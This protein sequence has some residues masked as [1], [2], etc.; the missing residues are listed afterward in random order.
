MTRPTKRSLRT[1]LLLIAAVATTLGALG[2]AVGVYGMGR[3]RAELDQVI[4]VDLGALELTR[5][6]QL[7]LLQAE[8]SRENMMLASWDDQRR[9]AKKVLDR[10][11]R[12]FQETLAKVRA[13]SSRDQSGV[14]E[15]VSAVADAWTP[16][17][18]AFVTALENEPVGELSQSAV[19]RDLAVR[20]R[21]EKLVS[22]LQQLADER[23]DRVA[24][25]QQRSAVMGKRM[26]LLIVAATLAST[27]ASA[28]VC[29]RLS[30][31]VMRQLGAEPHELAAATARVAEGD[32][33]SL[34]QAAP[35][36]G[37][38]LA[39]MQQMQE[40]LR[41]AMRAVADG[42]GI[43]TQSSTNISAG[44]FDL[45]RRTEKQADHVQRATSLV[46]GLARS[47]SVH[48]GHAREARES[49]ERATVVAGNAGQAMDGVQ[50][51]MT[52]IRETSKQVSEITS[53]IDSIAFQTNI[54]ALNAAVESA[55]AG[56]AGKGFS[57]VADE[58]RQLALR[59]SEASRDIRALTTTSSAQVAEGYSQVADAGRTIGQAIQEIVRIDTLVGEMETS[60][61]SLAASVQQANES[62]SV[63]EQ[64]TRQSSALVERT[65]AA[66]ESLRHEADRL[67]AAVG[68][69][70][71]EEE[72]EGTGGLEEKQAPHAPPP[73][74]RGG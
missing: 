18:A 39:S 43:V 35:L 74:R 6:A 16:E 34:A 55:R 72:P 58:V 15:A 60:N 40:R 47:M 25:S 48:S 24:K 69:F 41:V 32:L 44:N 17:I 68:L 63:I 38:V 4:D 49:V 21:T 5:Q 10:N 61:S 46:N 13:A 31:R 66:A 42:A 14:I 56:A 37:S 30:R 1:Q 51:A 64:A 65:A 29:W 71:I 20:V 2:A 23:V 27:L 59:C 53:L 52:R 33:V 57:L 8:V 26:L 62:I 45:S 9:D 67:A 54:L 11:V 19:R 3:I 28:W 7:G 36:A 12:A 73:S 22:A 50:A 70:K